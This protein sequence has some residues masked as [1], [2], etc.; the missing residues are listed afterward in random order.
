MTAKQKRKKKAAAERARK[1]AEE[2]RLAEEGEEGKTGNDDEEGTEEVFYG[3]PDDKAWTD[4]SAAQMEA[5]AKAEEGPDR[6]VRYNSSHRSP[7]SDSRV[8]TLVSVGISSCFFTTHLSL[9]LF[10]SF[11][12]L[13]CF[14]LTRATLSS[15]CAMLYYTILYHSS[16]TTRMARN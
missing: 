16:H 3:A 13:S 9:C 10:S 14:D 5:E 8:L 4:K 2:E 1:Q 11:P 6:S 7:R 15:F 12:I